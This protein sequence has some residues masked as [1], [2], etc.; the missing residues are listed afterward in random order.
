MG[1]K[2]LILFT[3]KAVSK[4]HH[5]YLYYFPA[6]FIVAVGVYFFFSWDNP[7]E[8]VEEEIV[9]LWF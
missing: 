2:Y 8:E 7:K 6:V 4:Q 1:R 5:F 3:V 9:Y